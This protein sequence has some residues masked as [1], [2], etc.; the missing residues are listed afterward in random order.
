MKRRK[1]QLHTK[2]IM[3]KKKLQ[4]RKNSKHTMKAEEDSTI[5]IIIYLFFYIEKIYYATNK[6]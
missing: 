5:F 2:I 3:P 4:L 6:L 1:K